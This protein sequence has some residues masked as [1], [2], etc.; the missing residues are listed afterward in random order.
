MNLNIKTNSVF[1]LVIILLVLNINFVFSSTVIV[2]TT[3]P[4]IYVRYDKL[5]DLS[6]VETRLEDQ[7]GKVFEVKREHSNISESRSELLFRPLSDLNVGNYIFSV[8]ACDDLGNCADFWR[9]NFRVE[10]PR[11]KITWKSPR[12]GLFRETSLPVLLE[13]N[14]ESICRLDIADGNFNELSVKSTNQVGYSLNH[15]FNNVNFFGET[16]Y[17]R[18]QDRFGDEARHTQLINYDNQQPL[19]RLSAEDVYSTPVRTTLS[20]EIINGKES[21]CRYSRDQILEFE[22][23]NMVQSSGR[24]DEEDEQSYKTKLF[25]N[26]FESDL[27]DKRL[28]R[29]YV[30]CMSKSGVMSRIESINID[31]DKEREIG[32]RI[33]SPSNYENMSGLFINVTTT[34]PTIC[35]YKTDRN[36]DDYTGQFALGNTYKRDHITTTRVN[37]EEGNNYIGVRCNDASRI[38]NRDFYFIVDLTNPVME[39]V[40]IVTKDTN[41]FIITEEDKLSFFYSGSDNVSGIDFYKYQI[42]EQ[43]SYGFVNITPWKTLSNSRE[44]GNHTEFVKLKPQY[45]YF[46][47]MI[48]VDKSGRESSPLRSRAVVYEENKSVSLCTG[49]NGLCLLGEPCN[50]NND[51]ESLFCN[52]GICKQPSC[53]DGFKNGGETDIDCGGE[54][55]KCGIGKSCLI[56]SD[57]STDNCVNGVCRAQSHCSNDKK[58][59][60]ESDVDCGGSCAGCENGK[61]CYTNNDCLSNNCQLGVGDSGICFPA[62]V[63]TDGDGIPDKLDNCPLVPNGPELGTCVLEGKTC[64]SNSE[65]ASIRYDYCSMNQEDMSGNGVGDACDNDID[66]DGIPNDWEILYGLNPLDPSDA[67]EDWDNDGISNYDEFR[68]GTNPRLKDT[69]GDGWS[70]YDEYFIY[71]TDPTDP[72]C[73]P[74]RTLAFYI[75]FTI[76]SLLSLLGGYYI[77]YAKI[78]NWVIGDSNK[79]KSIKKESDVKNKN[80]ISD[81]KNPQKQS[82]LHGID[83]NSQ[84]MMPKPPLLNQQKNIYEQKGSYNKNNSNKLNRQNLNQVNNLNM[85]KNFSNIIKPKTNLENLNKLNYSNNRINNKLGNNN[86]KATMMKLDQAY[87]TENKPSL[88]SLNS[89]IKKSDKAESVYDKLPKK[90][91]KNTNKSDKK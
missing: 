84:H 15:V 24:Y 20:I 44:T 58:D 70:D 78:N 46:V 64:M 75:I 76:F 60:D 3:N 62:E 72:N 35:T 37:F 91:N 74:R 77:Y 19:I 61:I 9:G 42:N 73:Y 41:S 13:T 2:E 63:D 38:Q 25:Q 5:I 89:I 8:S 14:R 53:D 49:P 81:L 39:N 21:V 50:K 47:E 29:F 48:V 71:G 83:K 52:E 22:A 69:D 27:V 32:I 40:T 30:Q 51:C 59:G 82:D 67:D 56:N 31:V 6:K 68:I 85:Q 11:L 66:G 10:L 36:S 4:D 12:F 54:C 65:C 55:D 43:G 23:M 17:I 87:K 1:I 80:N 90:S 34:V 18:C 57:C 26:L 7:E 16:L 86:Q 45:S 88:N 33:I 79:K 28:N